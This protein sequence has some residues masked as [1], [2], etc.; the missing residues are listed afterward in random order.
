ME[1]TMS[2][3]QYASLKTSSGK[4]MALEGMEVSGDVRG[5][6]LDMHVTQR[7]FNTYDCHA[8]IVYTFPLPWGAVLLN[9]EVTLGDQKLTGAVVE[10]KQ[11]EAEYEEAL[12]VGDASIMLEKNSDHSYSLSLGNIAP[13][14]HCVIHFK[15]AQTLQFEQRGLRLLIPTV[16]APRYDGS[17]NQNAMQNRIPAY[18]RP[19]HDV[20]AEYPF[21]IQLRIHGAM[22]HSRVASPTHS[23]AIVTTN[24]VVTLSLAQRGSLDRD[25]VLILD[26]LQQNSVTVTGQDKL[27]TNHHVVMASFCPRLAQE[28]S[29]SIDVNLLVDCSGSMAGASIASARRALQAIVGQLGEGDRYSLSSFGST[30]EHRS[31]AMWKATANSKL[32]AQ[33]WINNLDATLGGTEMEAALLSTFTLSN[34]SCSDV[35]MITDGE[36][37]GIENVMASAKASGHRIFIVGIGTSPAESHLRRLAQ[38]TGGACDFVAPGEAVDLAI[39]RMFARLRSPR[40]ES[41]SLAW[42]EECIP[43]CV[44]NLNTNVFDSDTV[45]VFALLPTIPEGELRLLGRRVGNAEQEEIGSVLFGQDVIEG[46]D[47]SRVAASIWIN[48]KANTVD[49]KIAQELAVSYQLVTEYTNFLLVHERAEEDKASD[50]PELH[51]VKQMPPAGWGGTGNI[52]FLRKDNSSNGFDSLS[53]PAVWRRESA[54]DQVRELSTAGM[55]TYD[56]PAFLRINISDKSPY[57]VNSPGVSTNRELIAVFINKSNPHFWASE[58]GRM[59]LT[60]LG[61]SAWLKLIPQTQWPTTYAE[62][63]KIDVGDDVLDWLELIIGSNHSSVST[64]AMVVASFL[65]VMSQNEVC[66]NLISQIRRT[67]SFKEIVFRLREIFSAQRKVVV[68]SNVDAGTVQDITDAMLGIQALYWPDFI[69]EEQA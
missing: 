67:F 61:L 28:E 43:I 44:S 48:A 31:R 22:A 33:R 11:A 39:L 55:D 65:Y 8:E 5:L 68:D 30:V 16:I 63:R 4:Q 42:P 6:M 32:A 20:L 62:L 26:Q 3:L 60:P 9:I 41:I 52:R 57:S 66:Q 10:K 1:M 35:L 54:S 64:E 49:E 40:L 53:R 23:I 37:D 27:N 56:L 21:D 24:D 29:P 46:D 15:Y 38:A 17:T 45:T 34:K 14:E 19:Q 25:F 18:L 7:F 13:K 59:K 36:I 69:L 58:H 2:K 47:F 51:Q 12:S 50:M